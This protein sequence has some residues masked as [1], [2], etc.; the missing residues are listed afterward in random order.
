MKNK[1]ANKF[2]QRT[3]KSVAIFAKQKIAPLSPAADEGVMP[4][5]TMHSENNEIFSIIEQ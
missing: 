4:Q 1:T 2:I 3:V 5:R